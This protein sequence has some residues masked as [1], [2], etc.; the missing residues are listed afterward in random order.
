V[1]SQDPT[2]AK[3][4]PQGKQK[5][6]VRN[7]LLQPLLQVK[8]GLY[9]ILISILFTLTVGAILYVNFSGL[10]NAIF[11]LTDAEAEV[12]EI[13]L[14]YWRGTRLAILGSFFI[15]FTATVVVS[16][17]YTHK[18]VGPTVAFRRHIRLLRE[19]G[20]HARTFLRKGDAFREVAE[21]LNQL[22]E[23]LEKSQNP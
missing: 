5:R 21:E 19:G 3:V 20:Y 18:L 2:G 23:V 14:E 1:T 16:V 6:L 15:Y 22:S 11:L 9:A 12:R 8:L 7:Y 10:A 4:A 13:L 17:L